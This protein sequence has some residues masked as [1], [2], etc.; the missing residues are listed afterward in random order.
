[1]FS[2]EQLIALSLNKNETVESV[3][4]Q[5]KMSSGD[6]ISSYLITAWLNKEI[7]Q[8]ELVFLSKSMHKV[9]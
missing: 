8:F 5:Y 7:G 6:S 3:A 2:L 9:S 1:M 4:L